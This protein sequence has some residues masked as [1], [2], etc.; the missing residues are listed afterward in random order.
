MSRYSRDELERAFVHYWRTGAAGDGTVVAY[1]AANGNT[2]W[3]FYIGVPGGGGPMTTYALDGQQYLAVAAG[4]R[5]WAFTLNGNIPPAQGQPSPAPA[6]T[7]GFTGLIEDTNSIETA[8]ML[9]DMAITGKRYAFDEHTFH[10]TR[11]RVKARTRVTWTNNGIIPHTIQPTTSIRIWGS[12]ATRS[13]LQGARF[14]TRY[15]R[16]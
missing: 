2:L 13:G 10:P 5:V 12:R 4:R 3:Q 1:D 16:R 14:G 8:S 15:T 11:A 9:T 6:L 7:D